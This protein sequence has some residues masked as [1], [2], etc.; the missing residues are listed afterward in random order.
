MNLFQELSK[1]DRSNPSKPFGRHLDNG[2]A[3]D[4]NKMNA[5]LK[6]LEAFYECINSGVLESSEVDAT[7]ATMLEGYLFREH[8]KQFPEA[9]GHRFIERLL[10]KPLE[11]P[12]LPIR[13]PGYDHPSLWE[14]DGKIFMFASQPYRM[15]QH[16]M[17]RIVEYCKENG[18]NANI[19]PRSWHRPLSTLLLTYTRRKE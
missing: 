10:G 3:K 2:I 1:S 19:S 14:K 6:I 12:G 18:L 7:L 9:K 17:L 8:A 16:T 15:D 11:G 13:P 4:P 5:I